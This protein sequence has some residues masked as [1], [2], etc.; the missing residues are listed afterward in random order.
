MESRS[1]QKANADTSRFVAKLL[2]S[3]VC[4][5]PGIT[6]LLLLV[7]LLLLLLLLLVSSAATALAAVGDPYKHATLLSKCACSQSSSFRL[8]VLHNQMIV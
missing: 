3:G 8:Y 4:R 7:L 5:A 2:M 1:T 6:L